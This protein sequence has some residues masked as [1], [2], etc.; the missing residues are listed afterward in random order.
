[1]AQERNQKIFLPHSVGL[2]LKQILKVWPIPR[3]PRLAEL[4]EIGASWFDVF[5]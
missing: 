2:W 5:T 3:F 4:A 1:M